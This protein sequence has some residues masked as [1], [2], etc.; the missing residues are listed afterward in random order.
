MRVSIPLP[1]QIVIDDVGWWSG[2]N[3]GAQNGP[4]R[5]GINRDH[6]VED[7][8]AIASLGRQLGMKPACAFVVVEWDTQQVLR[9]IPSATWMGSAWDNSRWVGPWLTEAAQV[10]RDNRDKH[11]ELTLH[12]VGHEYWVNGVAQ[13]ANWHNGDGVMW[14]AEDLRR[15]LAAYQA[16][17]EQHDL[18]G[19]PDSFVACA[20]CYR[21]DSRGQ[22]FAGLLAEV[23]VRYNGQPFYVMHRE[24]A[25]Q[26]PR[27][28]IE[29]GI[30]TIDRGPDVLPWCEMNPELR[31][32]VSGPI[33]GAHWANFLHP[34]PAHNEQVIAQWVQHLRP[35]GD[36]FFRMLSASTSDCWTQFVYNQTAQ[37]W[38][39]QATVHFDFT[40]LEAL[41]AMPLN[42][43]F[44]VKIMAEEG[45]I[46]TSEDFSIEA[47]WDPKMHYFR[48]KL[49]RLSHATSALM[50]VQSSR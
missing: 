22:G 35:Y 21:F 31:F 38:C 7:Y 2:K 9:H 12:G 50:R 32:Q 29:A 5:T 44:H 46:F 16:I 27:F 6:T 11:L 1:L 30:L 19:M 49:Q 47:E 17:L 39:E 43:F 23:G 24:Q 25:L 26:H 13:R 28:G 15:H 20:G 45:S 3:D 4:F 34:N 36:D 10:I 42:E 48:V 8:V 37:A 40:A 18:G 14:P 33:C 41:P